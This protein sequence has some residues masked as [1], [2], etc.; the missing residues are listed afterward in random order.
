MAKK[1]VSRT[2]NGGPPIGESSNSRCDPREDIKALA[3]QLFV[4]NYNS[5][6]GY[7]LES[8]AEKAI[9][10]AEAFFAILHH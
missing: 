4:Q 6:S 1:V 9:E 3:T 10:D 8:S 7:T 5:R 2:V